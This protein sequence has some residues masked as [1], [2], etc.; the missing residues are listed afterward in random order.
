MKYRTT[1]ILSPLPLTL[2]P[3]HYFRFLSFSLYFP[4]HFSFLDSFLLLPPPRAGQWARA[5]CVN[6]SLNLGTILPYLQRCKDLGYGKKYYSDL[7]LSPPHLLT[8]SSPHLLLSSP[9][10]PLTGPPFPR[11]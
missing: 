10:H 5:L 3:P 8:S 9:P 11:A 1:L 4:L 2:L 6:G 7:C